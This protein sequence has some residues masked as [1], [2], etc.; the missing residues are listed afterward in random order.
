MLILRLVP[1]LKDVD[2]HIAKVTRIVLLTELAI[3]IGHVRLDNLFHDG[4]VI[5]IKLRALSN[6][7]FG[8]ELGKREKSV[9]SVFLPSNDSW[10]LYE[11]THVRIVLDNDLRKTLG[12]TRILSAKND[13][14]SQCLLPSVSESCPQACQP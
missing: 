5:G 1:L 13:N 6:L 3:D 8:Q 9:S 14:R 11:E 10:R 7:L 12:P 4:L 2:H